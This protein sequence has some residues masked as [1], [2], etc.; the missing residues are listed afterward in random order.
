MNKKT[1]QEAIYLTQE[2]LARFWQLDPEY[3]LNC[4]DDNVTWIGSVQSQFME[5]K[6][7]VAQDFRNT[8]RELK[9]C[10]LLGQEFHVVQNS[11]NSCTVM[12]RYLTTTDDSVEYFLQVQQRCTF[13]WEQKRGELRIRHIHVSNPMGELKL[14][15]GE[16]FVN[17]MGKMA[18]QYLM[19]HIRALQD[20]RRLIV[21]DNRETT[22]FLLLSEI[23]CAEAH[24]R[25][26]II[27]TTSGQ[28]IYARM[29]MT[30]FIAAAGERFIPVHRSHAVNQ[31]YISC[32][33]KYE[34]ILLDGRKI[35]IPVKKYKE[36]RETLTGLHDISAE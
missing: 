32:V 3:V 24:G 26:C 9:P 28:E 31:A 19:N 4:C 14:A 29:N 35:P 25:N 33:Q 22:H 11:G 2:C 18:Q 21:T 17:T 23:V 1:L 8:T 27:Y 7:A 13:V 12:G 10:H 16:M 5:G 20:T 6:D 36:V 30:D 34:V 15:K